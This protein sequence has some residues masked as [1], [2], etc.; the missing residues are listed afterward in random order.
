MHI[1]FLFSDNFV[2]NDYGI[3]DYNLK[4]RAFNLDFVGRYE[5]L[6]DDFDYICKKLGLGKIFLPNGKKVE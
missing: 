4:G 1:T 3:I 5:N 6:T 2:Q